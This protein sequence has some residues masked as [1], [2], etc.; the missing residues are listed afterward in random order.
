MAAAGRYWRAQRDALMP[1]MD[2]RLPTHFVES[3]GDAGRDFDRLW[4]AVTD[5]VDRGPLSRAV[6]G[7]SATAMER[8]G[9]S[10]IR[11]VQLQA[12]FD[13]DNPQAQQWLAGRGAD[14]VTG[15]ND[16]TRRQLRGVIERGVRD[17]QSYGAIADEISRRFAGFSDASVLGHIRTRAELVA[18]TEIGE[19]Y[20]APR[21]MLI[22]DLEAA[23]TPPDKR[24]IITPDERLC[25]VCAPAGTDGWVGRRDVF[26]NGQLRPLGHPGCRCDLGL[27]T[28]GQPPADR[29]PAGSAFALA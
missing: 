19:A 8:G 4:R 1:R 25:E 27:R 2:E 23:G 15:I 14:L 11:D 22:D 10:A 26:S 29:W 17:R 18:V 28:D 13:L 16:E 3:P 6:E 24:W 5:E 20:M 7:Q 9:A 21:D 12:S